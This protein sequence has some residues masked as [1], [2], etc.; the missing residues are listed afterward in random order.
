MKNKVLVYSPPTSCQQCRLTKM[1]LDKL[2]ITFD[3]RNVESYPD[4][5]KALIAQHGRQAPIV[6]AGDRVWT[7]FRPDLI[8]SL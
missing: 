1:A 5:V 8:A 6:V 7:G 4:E 3:D 2:G